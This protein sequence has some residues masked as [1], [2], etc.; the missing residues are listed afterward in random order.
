MSDVLVRAEHLDR[1]DAGVTTAARLAAA[2]RGGLTAV[3]VVPIGIP[4]LSP[5]DPGLLAATAALEVSRQ[6]REAE[7]RAA[8]FTAWAS[9]MG[10]KDP[11]WLTAAGDAAQALTRVAAWH[12]MLVARVDAADDDPWAHPGGVG[13]MI[14]STRLPTLVLPAGA[15]AATDVAFAIAAVAWN[16]TPESARALHAALPLLE[17]AQRVVIL[18]GGSAQP[19][20]MMPPLDLAHWTARH[21]PNAE[22]R[23]LGHIGDGGEATGAALLAAARESGADLLVMGAYGHTRLSEWVLGG[24]TRHLLSNTRIPLLMRH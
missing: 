23:T 10:A 9:S 17:R 14:L 22:R 3:H 1:W 24:V 8:E 11:V 16:A 6:M 4:P 5:Y 7:A 2:L 19:P 21:L 13:R 18:D 15:D 20:V 12:D